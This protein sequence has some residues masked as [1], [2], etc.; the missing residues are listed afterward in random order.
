MNY[1]NDEL[2][3]YGIKGQKWG[4][5]R[6]QNAD[7]SLT[8]AGKERYYS[9]EDRANLYTQSKKNIEN[10]KFSR[11]P[12][13]Y[14]IKDIDDISEAGKF[15]GKQTE[16]ITKHFDEY[17]KS[18][19]QDLVDMRNNKKFKA[20]CKKHLDRMFGGPD[21]IDD[22]DFLELEID[23][24]LF[25]NEH[26]YLSDKTKN[27]YQSFSS[28]IDQYYKNVKSITEDIVGKYG[29]QPITQH[30]TTTVNG[31]GI[32]K[33]TVTTTQD[34]SYKSAVENTLHELGQSTWVRYLRNHE[35]MAYIDSPNYDLLRQTIKEEY[36]NGSM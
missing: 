3:H 28:G 9:D 17:S 24:Y 25:D 36:M 35:E 11:G 2:Y 13:D 21:Q 15:L 29:D 32:F 12:M 10:P 22:E 30:R 19:D 1:Y 18:Y 27:A 23:D 34:V 26:K 20:D 14:T 5:R 6:Y 4:V 31:N 7:G 8:D 33:T 16:A